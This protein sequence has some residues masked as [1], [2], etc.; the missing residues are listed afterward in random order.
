MSNAIP[1]LEGAFD[2]LATAG[3][4]VL[5]LRD[6]DRTATT[7][8]IVLPVHHII[9][10]WL[11]SRLISARQGQSVSNQIVQP[12]GRGVFVGSVCAITANYHTPLLAPFQ[13]NGIGSGLDIP[14]DVGVHGEKTK[15][16][17]LAF[18]S[19]DPPCP[20]D[21]AAETIEAR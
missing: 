7:L 9:S 19:A 20:T 18:A 1:C 11:P 2:V 17:P 16:T 10:R 4:F 12:G 3:L 21:W 5:P 6:M 13:C 8:Q 14:P 15:R